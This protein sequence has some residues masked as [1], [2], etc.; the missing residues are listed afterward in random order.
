ML[1][2]II[3]R[4]RIVGFGFA[5]VAVSMVCTIHKFGYFAISNDII[6]GQ[7]YRKRLLVVVYISLQFFIGKSRFAD[8][9]RQ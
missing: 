1:Q 4:K 9:F 6:F 7:F 2:N 8:H 5:V 3:S